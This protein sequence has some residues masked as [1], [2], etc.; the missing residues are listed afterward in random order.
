MGHDR[1]ARGLA[2]FLRGLPTLKRKKRYAPIRAAF[3]RAFVAVEVSKRTLGIAHLLAAGKC[4]F[5]PLFCSIHGGRIARE[6]SALIWRYP[7]IVARSTHRSLGLYLVVAVCGARGLARFSCSPL[8]ERDTR[9]VRAGSSVSG[10]GKVASRLNDRRLI[11]GTQDGRHVLPS[12]LLK[13]S[14]K[15]DR[16]IDPGV[17]PCSQHR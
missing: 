1:G 17:L 4:C 5:R 14:V 2:Q 12:R 16:Q 3:A 13:N 9:Q 10:P 11:D 7:A 15:W 6:M 8:I